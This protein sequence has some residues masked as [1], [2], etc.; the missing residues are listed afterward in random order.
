MTV[1]KVIS[2][3]GD[4][5]LNYNDHNNHASCQWQVF[6]ED[7]M[8]NSPYFRALLDRNKF[9]E[10]RNLLEQK[11]SLASLQTDDQGT[12]LSDETWS[13]MPRVN[14]PVDEFSRKFGMDAV[15]LLLRILCFDSLTDEEKGEFEIELKA[16]PVS[17][18]GRLVE[19]AD[20]FNSQTA[21]RD[22]LKKT[23]YAFGKSRSA[24]HRFHP[25]LLKMREE[26]IRL[27]IFI[28]DFLGMHLVFQVMT[29]T[30][31]IV[32]SKLWINGASPP[33]SDTTFRWQC[34]SEGLEG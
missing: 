16:K 23:G 34:F 25:A 10:G 5:L 12:A 31:I 8:L 28:A 22:M 18:V 3:K 32:G 29:H 17:I 13:Q 11:M 20:Y 6:S 4:V 26:R 33:T 24:L 27:M 14:L 30:L 7:L 2:R 15:E 1:T 21:V 9:S 19:V